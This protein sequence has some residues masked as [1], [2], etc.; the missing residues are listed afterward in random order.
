[1]HAETDPMTIPSDQRFHHDHVDPHVRA[2]WLPDLILGAQDGLVNTLGVVLGV[3][4][5]SGDA[6]VTLAT[7]VAAGAAEALSM[8]AVAYTS[9]AARGELFRAERAREL[10]HVEQAPDL[11]RDEVRA[12]YAQKGFSGELLENIVETICADRQRWV[13]EMMREEHH[14]EEV[15]V[16]ASL[17]SAAL[18]GVASLVGALLPVLPFAVLTRTPGVVAAVVLGVAGLLA[19]GMVKARITG[20]SR[21]RGALSIAAIGLA[22]ALVGY[23]IGAVLG[24]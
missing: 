14:L 24:G 8:A 9:S 5:A 11:E 3:A 23:A 19:L 10:R 6:R 20:I 2:R 1:M 16:R 7:G 4:A 21:A 15:D 22:S 17:A 12:L 13:A 18:V